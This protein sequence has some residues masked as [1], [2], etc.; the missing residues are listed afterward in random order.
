MADL[1]Q[2]VCL[3][4][5]KEF[6][7]SGPERRVHHH[8]ISSTKHLKHQDLDQDRWIA[9]YRRLYA[10]EHSQSLIRAFPDADQVLSSLRVR[11][12][13]VAIINNKGVQA[14]HAA[15]QNDGL[16]GYVLETLI[17]GD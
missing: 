8:T 1:Q 10:H 6:L 14:V 12:I 9:E 15:L 7:A 17:V 11:K 2:P 16:D 5:Q 4:H 13:P 3:L